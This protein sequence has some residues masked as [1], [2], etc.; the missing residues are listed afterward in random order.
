MAIKELEL[1]TKEKI[2]IDNNNFKIIDNVLEIVAIRMN[3][4]SILVQK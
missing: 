2:V 1:N 3:T 4:S